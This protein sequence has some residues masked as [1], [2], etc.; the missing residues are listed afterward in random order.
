MSSVDKRVLGW[1]DFDAAVESLAK[2]IPDSATGLYGVPRGGQPLAVSLSH[3]T[4]LPLVG[5][6]VP[7]VVWI[8]DVIET[9]NSIAE[10]IAR[11]YP[12]L[13]WIMKADPQ[14]ISQVEFIEQSDKWIVF[15][16][17]TDPDADA[18]DYYEGQTYPIND[19]YLSVQGEGVL[20]GVPM[21]ILRLHGC[22][23][24]CPWCDTK[25][26]WDMEEEQ[27]QDDLRDALGANAKWSRLSAD[28]IAQYI[29]KT[30]RAPYV[31]L[32]GGE[33]A[34]YDL[35]PLVKTLQ[36]QGYKVAIETSGTER[37]HIG[38]GFDHV[39]VSPKMDMPG[40]KLILP[41]ALAV[42]DEIKQVIALEKDVYRLEGLL[43]T[44]RLKKDTTICLQPVSQ[45]KKA[46]DICLRV[47]QER[48]W[49]LSLQMHKYLSIA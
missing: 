2:M 27:H 24:G 49:R 34:Q 44:V 25:E 35:A 10:A 18:A 13:S 33:P 19:V 39:C 12:V 6:T 14:E 31:L 15:P 36:A 28:A 46:T 38:A 5:A 29:S 22:A 37:G 32:T 30:H 23:V 3:K 43:S 26:T 11:G 45:S 9:G 17:E 1:T 8:E 7:G 20:T 4:G 47:C 42:A 16:W 41:D 40:G 21:V 48:G